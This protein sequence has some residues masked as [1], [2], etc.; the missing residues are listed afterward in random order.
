MSDYTPSKKHRIKCCRT[1]LSSVKGD[2]SEGDYSRK[3]KRVRDGTGRE[4]GIEQGEAEESLGRLNGLWLGRASH[5]KLTK[6][7]DYSLPVNKNN[8]SHDGELFQPD[9]EREWEGDPPKVRGVTPRTAGACLYW[10]ELNWEGCRPESVVGGGKWL[11]GG[12]P[13]KSGPGGSNATGNAQPR[14]LGINTLPC[15]FVKT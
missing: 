4:S 7:S 1:S 6:G 10:I 13:G 5:T 15:Y 11:P 3:Q 8:V 2:R 9:W 12:E 14:S